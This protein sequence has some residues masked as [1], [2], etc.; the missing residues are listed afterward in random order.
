[1]LSWRKKKEPESHPEDSSTSLAETEQ[2]PAAEETQV[3]PSL[4]TATDSPSL[5]TAE[6]EAAV[7][8]SPVSQ[9]HAKVHQQS[10]SPPASQKSTSPPPES[11][12]APA[13]CWSDALYNACVANNTF[14][15]TPT[16]V[17]QNQ[18][19]VKRPHLDDSVLIFQKDTATTAKNIVEALHKTTAPS[20]TSSTL[21]RRVYNGVTGAA[22]SAAWAATKLV[23]LVVGNEDDYDE[24]DLD[25][26]EQ[27]D[28]VMNESIAL[29]PWS[30]PVICVG[31]MK[32]CT[33]QLIP[34]CNG[35]LQAVS[36]HGTG[37]YSFAEWAAA[38]CDCSIAPN[39][40]QHDLDLLEHVLVESGHAVFS[41]NYLVFGNNVS[42]TNTDLIQ[43]AVALVQLNLSIEA[44]E[45]LVNQRTAQVEECTRCA[46]KKVQQKNVKGAKLELQKRR[47]LQSKIDDSHGSLLNLIQAR[48]TLEASQFQQTHVLAPMQGATSALKALRQG[49][50]VE[51]VDDIILDLQEELNHSNEMSTVLAAGQQQEYDEAELLEELN[52]LTLEDVEEESEAQESTAE[53][54]ARI[55]EHENENEAK[56]NEETESQDTTLKQEAQEHEND[57]KAKQVSAVETPAA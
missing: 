34:H 40:Q 51:N 11:P 8:S 18:Q 37:K 9:D 21:S 10:S 31:S 14:M 16:Q 27:A 20:Q 2:Q 55:E 48:D 41:G 24:A 4:A 49:C 30:E 47:L 23:Q 25:Y 42:S 33:N 57:V 5:V 13:T 38:Q 45:R 15:L 28:D 44:N 6:P 1:M 50:T 3:A 29:V 56:S 46:T 52:R 32:E 17:L 36:R 7:A 22:S 53:S 19:Q 12:P 39:L 35:E 54:S 43:V 26:S